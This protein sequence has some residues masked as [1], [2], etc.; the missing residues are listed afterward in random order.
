MQLT[1]TQIQNAVRRKLL[2]EG[3][4]LVSD[5]TLLLNMN[6][7]YDD[8]RYRTFSKDQL[9][10]ATIT[11]S[12]GVGTLPANFGTAYANGYA[13]ET[14]NQTYVEKTLSDFDLYDNDYCYAVD[15]ANNQILVTPSSTS[16][17]ILRFW[18]SYDALSSSQNPEINGYFHELIIYGALSRIHEDLQNEALAVFYDGKY[19]EGLV[20]KTNA[21]SNYEDDNVGGNE[22]FSY[23]K[24]F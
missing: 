22:F 7:A 20:K 9:Q 24:L 2:E 19:E 10:K 23:T 18:P 6:L 15:L 21:L 12:N 3:T 11:L 1:T 8:L 4:E 16:Q 13:S 14:D 5:E 17:L